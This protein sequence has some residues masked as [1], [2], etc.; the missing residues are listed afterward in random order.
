MPF[1]SA[2]LQPF[3]KAL[4]YS[5]K[6]LDVASAGRCTF[7]CCVRASDGKVA[8]LHATSFSTDQPNVIKSRASRAMHDLFVAVGADGGRSVT[9]DDTAAGAP[10]SPA[11]AL[12]DALTA[13]VGSGGAPSASPWAAAPSLAGA[14][15]GASTAS[16]S[17]LQS[18]A[19]PQTAASPASTN[20]RTREAARATSEVTP[21]NLPALPPL[22]VIPE[23]VGGDGEQDAE[24][25]S[26]PPRSQR[27][28]HSAAGVAHRTRLAA[29]TRSQEKEVI[30]SDAFVNGVRAKLHGSERQVLVSDLLQFFELMAE[31]VKRELAITQVVYAHITPV[32]I[33]GVSVKLKVVVRRKADPEVVALKVVNRSHLRVA[34]GLA[35]ICYML[36]LKDSFFTFLLDLFASGTRVL[37]EKRLCPRSKKVE[38]S[39]GPSAAANDSNLG[40][41]SG[42]DAGDGGAGGGGG[43]AGGSGGG[44]GGGAGDGSSGGGSHAGGDGDAGGNREGDMVP[45]RND[46][47]VGNSGERSRNGQ[48]G[49]RGVTPPLTPA[50]GCGR[51]G[52]NGANPP[53]SPAVGRGR[54]RGRD[55]VPPL[56]PAVGRGPGGRRGAPSIDGGHDRG[57]AAPRAASLGRPAAGTGGLGASGAG[58]VGSIRPT[59]PASAGGHAAGVRRQAGDADVAGALGRSGRRRSSLGTSSSPLA[60]MLDSGAGGVYW[61]PVFG[62]LAARSEPVTEVAFEGLARRDTGVEGPIFDCPDVQELYYDGR[63][64]GSGM[65]DWKCALVDHT[66]LEPRLSAVS[67]RSIA[68]DAGDVPCWAWDN[69][70]LTE[71]ILGRVSLYTLVWETRMTGY[72]V[73]L[74]SSEQ[75]PHCLRTAQSPCL[76]RVWFPMLLDGPSNLFVPCRFS[77]FLCVSSWAGRV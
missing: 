57:N 52:G 77:I 49:E 36:H 22:V 38:G 70:A 7:V 47:I 76:P 43:G 13:P 6:Q 16:V 4:K 15:G 66:D 50:V 56:A 17:L 69:G 12:A 46:G 25:D 53:L 45:A 28:V 10:A 33:L 23:L 55:A 39:D 68:S 27:D 40:H 37:V 20:R 8:L 75:G 65:V 1:F 19:S 26:A 60:R 3:V 61:H 24:E 48:G 59:P 63:V 32:A 14:A 62:V 11:P 74:L 34:G 18:T 5:L 41:D 54:G 71:A 72:A 30:L 21:A 64:V 29:I 42:N 9:G 44:G 67:L 51:G 31:Y 58:R 73:L 2:D 35:L